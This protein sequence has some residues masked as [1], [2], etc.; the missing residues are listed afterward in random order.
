MHSN[1][2]GNSLP[3]YKIAIKFESNII[4]YF[5][6]ISII[7][8]FYFRK[9]WLNT[10]EITSLLEELETNGDIVIELLEVNELSDGDSDK[11]DE[12]AEGTIDHL[13]RLVL[14]VPAEI[15]QEEKNDDE[16]TA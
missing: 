6:D 14:S 10:Y 13:I 3:G 12:E 9:K 8:I 16:F 1:I 5:Y 4:T 11:S 7:N 15:A 2:F